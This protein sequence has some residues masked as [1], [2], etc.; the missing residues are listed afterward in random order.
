[1]FVVPDPSP[2]V[3]VA[4]AKSAT[5]V[6]GA[7]PTSK[8]CEMARMRRLPV[9]PS[10]PWLSGLLPEPHWPSVTLLPV[11]PRGL[12]EAVPAVACVAPVCVPVQVFAAPET[13]CPSGPRVWLASWLSQL[14]SQKSLWSSAI[15]APPSQ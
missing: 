3:D 9:L 2:T 15:F 7:A 14:P 4:A 6:W 10:A 13:A 12:A 1:M 11:W 8:T 5:G